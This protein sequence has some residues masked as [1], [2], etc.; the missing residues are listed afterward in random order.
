M[1]TLTLPNAPGDADAVAPAATV[2]LAVPGAGVAAA[3]SA[4]I[5]MNAPTFPCQPRLPPMR[6]L[7]W[8]LPTT[9][10]HS[11]RTESDSMLWLDWN[12]T[13]PRTSMPAPP[14]RNGPEAP[15]TPMS[16]PRTTSP[17]DCRRTLF[18][19]STTKSPV[20]GL[21]FNADSDEVSPGSS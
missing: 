6:W 17:P 16:P 18:S 13:P 12:Q 7:V 8:M 2:R 20:F 3:G 9:E 21:A 19:A 4:G 10:P 5:G 14:E 11:R 15:C 1:P